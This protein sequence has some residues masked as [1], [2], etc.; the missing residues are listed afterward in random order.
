MGRSGTTMLTSMLNMHEEIVATPENEFILFSHSSY[1]NKNFDQPS[2]VRSFSKI[3]DYNFNNVINIWKPDNIEKRIAGLIHKS[4]ANV[5]KQ[6]YLDYPLA[7]D[8][9][10]DVKYI[11]D[12]NPFYSLHI[13]ILN[14]L[15]PQAKYIVIVRDYRDNIV[16]RKKYSDK[17][18]SLYELAAAWNYYYKQIFDSIT[19]YNLPFYVIRYEDLVKFPEQKLREICSFLGVDFCDEM[20]SFQDFS[21]KIK[22]HAKGILSESNYEKISNMHSNLDKKVN[23]ER[24]QAFKN[25]L[26]VTDINMLNYFCAKFSQKFNYNTINEIIPKPSLFIRMKYGYSYIKLVAFHY[27][28][29]LYYKFPVSFRLLF[30]QK[31]TKF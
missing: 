9:T 1:K 17:K 24:V 13:N 28:N 16:S 25:E 7:H 11:V 19:K 3:F 31:N 30:K 12:K 5:C 27:I 6:V 20:L 10:N 18:S 14:E 23:T 29:N 2:T 15:Y 8:K 26:S 22:Q 4:F 21:K